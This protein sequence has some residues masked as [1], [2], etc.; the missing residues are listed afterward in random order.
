MAVRPWRV[1][2]LCTGYGGLDLAV[3][4]AH[5]GARVVCRVER[6]AYVASLLIARMEEGSLDACP[7]WGDLATFDGRPWRGVVDCLIG[8]YPCQPFSVAGKR[9]GAD[10]PR[11][12]WPHV[13]RI[14]RECAPPVVF[15]ENVANHLRIGFREVGGELLDLGYR[16]EAGLFTAAEVGASHRRER[17]FVLAVSEGGGGGRLPG[18]RG[19][20]ERQ[21]GRAWPSHG[22]RAR[23]ADAAERGRG[24]PERSPLPARGEPDA[25]G[26][27]AALP[28]FPPGPA[29]RAAWAAVLAARPDL[30][31]AV[32]DPGDRLVP[33]PG[34]GAQGRAG[35]RSAGAG[36]LADA[37][38]E[39]RQQESRGAHGDEAAD[40]GRGAAHDHEPASG[41]EGA[42]SR[43]EAQV[44][45]ALRGLAHGTAAGVAGRAEQ[46]RAGGNGVVP[47]QA[48]FALSVLA[49]RISIDLGG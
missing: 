26:G 37:M 48:A 49:G 36:I 7:L 20:L 35:A 32:A 5:P 40:A 46:L 4:L 2:S 24:V 42:E 41:G 27:G 22:G 21:A 44:E 25:P 19:A 12:L 16:F 47:L 29:D 15:L 30:A 18:V 38:R 23:L 9:L 1:L 3:G 17:L 10:D 28:L 14:I 6:E 8:G 43:R 13:A 33:Q 11:H 39:R 31:P 34:R 45:S